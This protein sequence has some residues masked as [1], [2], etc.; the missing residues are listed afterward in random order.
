MTINVEQLTNNQYLPLNKNVSAAVNKQHKR[1]ALL[2]GCNGTFGSA[3][4]KELLAQGWQVKLLIRDIKKVPKWF[5]RTQQTQSPTTVNNSE[6]HIWLGDCS[7]Q[8]DVEQA[9]RDVDIIVYAANPVYNQWHKYAFAMLEPSIITAEKFG[10]HILFP[11]NVYGYNPLT[12]PIIDENSIQDPVTDKG[13]IRNQMERRLV[14]ACNNGATVTVIRS[15]D[16]IAKNSE[17][18]WINHFLSKKKKHWSLA[19]PSAGASL[20]DLNAPHQ[21]SYV[22]VNDLA[23]NSVALLDYDQLHNSGTYNHWCEPGLFSS[24]QDWLD[25]FTENNISVKSTSFPWWGLK[26]W[27]WFH[28]MMKEVMKMRY[29]W[30]QSLELDGS[31]IKKALGQNYHSTP[32]KQIVKTLTE[33]S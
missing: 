26:I 22:W 9:A 33:S 18:S 5:S 15:G 6:Q 11:G 7:V 10:L 17:T 21:H 31:K 1:S 29:L 8:S 12:T 32:L 19:D 4:G 25:A 23:K 20:Y 13:V 3:V 14:E 30:Q 2:I 27:S 28:S 24:H 16:F